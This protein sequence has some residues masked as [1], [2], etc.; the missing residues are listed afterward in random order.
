VK[1]FFISILFV[2]YAV[3]I[4]ALFATPMR[5]ANSEGPSLTGGS[6]NI[7]IGIGALQNETVGS[8]N[9][10]IG[11][12]SG[13]SITDENDIIIIGDHIDIPHKGANGYINIGGLELKHDSL[14]DIRKLIHDAWPKGEGMPEPPPYPCE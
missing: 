9:I 13:L 4:F 3:G 14:P 11:A 8:R 12:W 7:A 1:R 2:W 6:C 10:V 5:S